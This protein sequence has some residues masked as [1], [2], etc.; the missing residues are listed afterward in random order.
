MTMNSLAD[1]AAPF[2]R[3]DYIKITVFG[4][5]LTA[6]WNSLH[7]I[8]LPLRLLDFV[9]E[10]TKNTYLG[11][12]TFVGLVLAMLVQPIAGTVSDQSNFRWGRRRPFILLG[13]IATIMLLP[14]ISLAESSIV[15]FFF[16]CLLQISTNAA[17]GPFQAFIPDHVPEKKRGLASGVKSM[18]EIIGGIT[19][20]RLIGYFMS[21][22]SPGQGTLW[23]WLALGTL[24]AVLTVVMLATVLAVKEKPVST[25]SRITFMSTITRGFKIDVRAKP[26]FIYFLVSRLLIFMAL[27]TLQTFALYFLRDVIRVDNP[28]TATANLVVAIGI[29]MLAVV[30]PAG[31]LADRL[32]RRPVIMVS[33]LLGA[34]GVLV[35]LFATSYTIVLGGGAIIGIA[36]GGFVSA[37]WAL[38]TDLV[39]KGEE[40]KYLGLTNLATAGGSALARLI[41][42]AIDLFNVSRP[43]MGYQIMLVTCF[44]YF[45]IGSLL[46]LKIKKRN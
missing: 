35:L 41:G 30:Y 19:V 15:L 14:G 1:N 26:E 40:A 8:I 13:T 42:P 10:S 38:A 39:N 32:G 31:I 2:R 5:A 17:Q 29:G 6:L 20:V 22:Y 4:F 18:M 45:V 44:A 46:V 7:S 36:T 43:G 33:G 25:V 9:D 28:A 27:A 23:L 37:N 12:L 34:C 21:R 11:F 24:A 16:Y 3:L